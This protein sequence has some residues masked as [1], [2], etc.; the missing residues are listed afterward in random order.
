MKLTDLL[1]DIAIV[2]TIGETDREVTGIQF[3]SRR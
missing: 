1:Q 2:R 3:D